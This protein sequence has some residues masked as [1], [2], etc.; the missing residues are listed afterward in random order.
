[1]LK[2]LIIFGLLMAR[3]PGVKMAVRANLNLN[4][5]FFIIFFHLIKLVSYLIFIV[6]CRFIFIYHSHPSQLFFH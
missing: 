4:D 5:V 2:E 1:M 3:T 6:K